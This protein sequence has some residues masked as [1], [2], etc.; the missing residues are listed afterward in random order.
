MLW[1]MLWGVFVSS[2]NQPVHW[3]WNACAFTSSIADISWYVDRF[4]AINAK[5]L[6]LQA[7]R[8]ADTENRNKQRFILYTFASIMW[9]CY[10]VVLHKYT[11]QNR[12][13]HTH[14]QKAFYSFGYRCYCVAHI[15]CLHTFQI[16]HFIF[17]MMH[18]IDLQADRHRK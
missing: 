10:P 3:Y 11:M 17:G 9:D 8:V 12:H 14:T 15:N 5:G 2:P 16:D 4:D 18:L 6:G 1:N 7:Y 13:T